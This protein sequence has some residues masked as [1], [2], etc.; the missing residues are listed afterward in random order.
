MVPDYNTYSYENGLKHFIN[1]EAYKINASLA[2]QLA[3]AWMR[4]ARKRTRK[5][6]RRQV[7]GILLTNGCQEINPMDTEEHK[8]GVLIDVLN[9]ETVLGLKECKWPGRYQVVNTDYATFYL[10]GAHTK[11]SIEICAK[12]FKDNTR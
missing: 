1:L 6:S 9:K 5:S 4:V 7:N 8:D 3:H 2:I 10:D 11:E 12:W